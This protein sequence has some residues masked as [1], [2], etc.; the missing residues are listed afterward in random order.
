MNREDTCRQER[1]PFRPERH[2]LHL[3]FAG[4]TQQPRCQPEN[5]ERIGQMDQDLSEFESPGIHAPYLIID[6]KT[7]RADR[8]VTRDAARGENLL[9]VVE[10]EASNGGILNELAVDV[11]FHEL[12]IQDGEEDRQDHEHQGNRRQDCSARVSSRRFQAHDTG[13]RS[14]CD[15]CT[16]FPLF[17]SDNQEGT[18]S[19][20][21]VT[22][23]R[24]AN[25]CHRLAA[26]RRSIDH[27]RIPTACE[28]PQA[29]LCCR[30]RKPGPI[31]VL[32]RQR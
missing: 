5:Q 9:Q 13:P 2:D 18:H 24:L 11:E 1:R 7:Q 23:P 26:F 16:V 15:S 28:D 22:G 25:S 14:F 21:C 31:P 29:V 6:G 4:T 32:S 12:E 10:S 20:N 3:G 8:I 30:N 19:L 17:P 27:G